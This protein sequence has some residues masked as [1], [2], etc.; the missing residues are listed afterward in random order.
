MSRMKKRAVREFE[1]LCEKEVGR[2]N[3]SDFEKQKEKI[4]K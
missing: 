4:D 3:D 1:D 2:K